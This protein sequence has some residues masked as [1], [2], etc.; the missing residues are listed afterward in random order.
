MIFKLYKSPNKGD[1]LV[2]GVI[3]QDDDVTHIIHG[4]Y[5]GQTQRT[6]VNYYTEKHHKLPQRYEIIK[7][8][9]V[10]VKDITIKSVFYA[11]RLV[12]DL[13]DK[14]HREAI[15]NERKLGKSM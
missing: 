3:L 14:L 10:V 1:V 9:D 7:D 5:D 13:T 11:W 8:R 2:S 6:K 4:F 15:I 12:K